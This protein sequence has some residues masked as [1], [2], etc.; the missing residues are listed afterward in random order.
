MRKR[1]RTRADTAFGPAPSPPP[2]D[3]NRFDSSLELTEY[4]GPQI[5]GLRA[6]GGIDLRSHIVWDRALRL[7]VG[8]GEEVHLDLTDLE[9]IDSRGAAVLVEAANRLTGGRHVVV[10]HAPLCFQ[11]VMQVLWPEGTPTM[12]IDRAAR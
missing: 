3:G 10:H 2:A 4:G 7:A 6:A 9:F 11:R 5:V 12:K 8:H 1:T